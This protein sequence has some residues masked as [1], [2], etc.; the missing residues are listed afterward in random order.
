MK[1]LNDLSVAFYHYVYS[2]HCKNRLPYN[3]YC[4]G[5]D[6]KHCTIQSNHTS[7]YSLEMQ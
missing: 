2:S 1:Q 6:V 3:L 5:G 4:V 7:L